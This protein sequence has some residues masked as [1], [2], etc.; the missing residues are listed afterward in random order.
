[1]IK[2]IKFFVCALLFAVTLV[3]FLIPLALDFKWSN[4]AKSLQ[5]MDSF[6]TS[7]LNDTL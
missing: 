1:M 3:L 6:C 5:I 7:Y 2:I 4:Y